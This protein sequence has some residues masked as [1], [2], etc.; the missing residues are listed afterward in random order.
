M[1]SKGGKLL[2]RLRIQKRN[3]NHNDLHVVLLEAGFEWHDSKHRVY[4]H[5]DFPELGSYPI[6]R[7]DGLA[8][9]YAKD[10]LNLVEAARRLQER[11]IK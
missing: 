3:W 6:P 1:S 5:P 11:G 4:R 7:S 10:V 8:P 2:A 9:Q